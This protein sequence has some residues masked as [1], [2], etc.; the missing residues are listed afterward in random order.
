MGRI[1]IIDDDEA[2]AGFLAASI[3]ESY[4]LLMVEVC[5]QLAKHRVHFL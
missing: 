1:L 4:P 2:F 3:G 5:T